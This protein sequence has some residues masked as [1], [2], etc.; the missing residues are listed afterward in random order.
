MPFEV[1]QEIVEIVVSYASYHDDE[2]C[3][4]ML[5]V[6]RSFQAAVERQVFWKDLNL[7]SDDMELFLAYC[8]GPR[9]SWL[10]DIKLTITFPK[11]HDSEE[12]SLKCRETPQ[13]LQA[14]DELFTR[15]ISELFVALNTFRTV[16]HSL[17]MNLR[18]SISLLRP[19]P[20]RMTVSCHVIIAKFIT[21]VYVYSSPRSSRSC[22]Q[23]DS[24]RLRPTLLT[25][26]ISGGM[27][28]D[29]LTCGQFSTLYLDC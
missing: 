21:G 6:S 8:H 18:G 24:L 13:D 26:L 25:T 14:M 23:S 4:N 7:R 10:R 20:K 27:G 11:L 12:E 5:T 19:H 16:R 22:H 3:R 29:L 1:P 15:Q 28:C 9:I 17:G 2:T